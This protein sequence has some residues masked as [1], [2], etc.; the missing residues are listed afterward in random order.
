MVSIIDSA[1]QW[2]KAKAG[3]DVSETARALAFCDRAIRT[4]DDFLVVED[5]TQDARFASD[6]LVMGGNHL[7]FYAALPLKHSSG[8]VIGALYLMDTQSH[9]ADGAKH[10]FLRFMAEQI[11]ATL[12][13]RIGQPNPLSAAVDSEPKS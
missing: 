9:L 3:V 7:R 12:E 2:L 1:R 10:E 5:A 13:A 6:S 11:V 8:H 4:P